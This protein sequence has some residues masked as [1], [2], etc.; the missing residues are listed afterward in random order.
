MVSS[1]HNVI[2]VSP[3][4]RLENRVALITGAGRTDGIGAAIAR[5]LA[6]AGAVVAISDLATPS[7]LKL[8][9]GSDRPEDSVG[10]VAAQLRSTGATVAPFHCDLTEERDCEALVSAVVEEFGSC[11][12][13][14]NNAA[15][16]H[17][18]D[19]DDVS[20]VPAE[21]FDYQVAVNL[22]GSFLLSRL[23]IPHMRGR[24]WGRIVNI[25]SVAALIGF[26]ERASYSASK[27]GLVGLTKS[28]AADVIDDG[29][30]VNAV[31]PGIIRTGRYLA[32]AASES[33]THGAARGGI[34]AD[35]AWA[36]AYFASE[37]SSFV[38]GQVLAIDG[39]MSATLR[40]QP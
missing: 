1:L 18:L 22:R 40:A 30:T 8:P 15:A 32:S 14:I 39:G 13:L 23:A 37:Q 29:V 11:D 17:G 33:Y 21:A 38:T 28:T 3:A 25:A 7:R 9:P 10:T 19:R 31:C 34:P 24:K 35:V 36:V 20:Q 4:I 16:P 6:A 27:A 26:E 5:T 2:E 12:I